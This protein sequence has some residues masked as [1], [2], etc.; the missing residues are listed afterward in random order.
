AIRVPAWYLRDAEPPELFV[1]PDDRWEVNDV[2]DRC[3]NLVEPLQEVLAE[4]EQAIRTGSSEQ[5]S[6]LDEIFI[7]GP[8]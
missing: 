4:Y 6:P 2:A 7:A 5:L 8:E 3:A 1:K